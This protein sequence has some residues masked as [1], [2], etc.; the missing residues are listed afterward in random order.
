M[1]AYILTEASAF[2]IRNQ[3]FV[4]ATEARR[5]SFQDSLV[6]ERIHEQAYRDLGFQLID[7]PAGP[8]AGR[9]AL[10]LEAVS[11]L[12][13]VRSL[14]WDVDWHAK[15]REACAVSHDSIDQV[16]HVGDASAASLLRERAAAVLHG[17]DSGSSWT[18]ASPRLYPHQWSWDS[19]FIA[20]GWAHLDV[21]RAIAELEQL[22]A[23]Q[24]PSGMV[25]HI[26]F[27]GGPGVPY[28]P[29]PEWWDCTVTPAPPAAPLRTTGICQPPVHALALQRIWQLTPEERRPEIHA[30]LQ[31]LYPRLV[32]WHRYLATGRDPE[33][34]GL[35][36]TYHPWEGTD[37]SPRWDRALARIEVA[38]PGPYTRLDASTLGDPSQRPT[39]WDYD[40]YLWLVGT[41]KECGYDDAEIYRRHPF[42]IKDVFF[43]SVLVAANTAL[44]DLADVAGA[45]AGDREELKSWLARGH[46][47]LTR[48]FD[49]ESGLCLDYDVRTGEQIRLRTFA[50]FAPLFARTAD[51]GQRAAQLRLLDSEDFCGNPRLRWRLLPSTSLAEPVFKP[52]NY[53]RGPVWPII[54]W[55]LW[56]SLSELG[57]Q[58]RAAD[59]RRDALAQIAGDGDFAEYFEPVTGEP[60]GSPQQSW[61]AAVALDWLASGPPPA[62]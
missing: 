60:L 55:L 1:P 2:F 11:Q 15:D 33:G 12:Q 44:L 19:A 52:R 20:I 26:V 8:L 54:N 49:P 40:R 31:A 14:P 45:T 47:G 42:L 53:W 7:V 62:D 61:T 21:R 58:G 27:R 59:L 50:A 18:R 32:K 30:R 4:R 57:Y 3:G 13:R 38:R 41:L 17:N 46:D 23:A 36:T 56:H 6:F 9:V 34:S 5:I 22:F 25:P 29:G 39:D 35:V 51:A 43:S 28:F 16:S 48:C 24:W 37:N 10:I